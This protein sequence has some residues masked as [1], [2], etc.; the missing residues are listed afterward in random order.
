MRRTLV[1]WWIASLLVA[2]GLASA[3]TQ[4]QP[5]L[6]PQTRM[7]PMLLSGPD[8]GFRVEGLNRSGQPTGTLVVRMNGEWVEVGTDARVHP[9]K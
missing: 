3:V 9:I 5:R 1:L 4:A 7:P 8:V 2:A 6:P